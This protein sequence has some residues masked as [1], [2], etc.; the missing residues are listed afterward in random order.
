V[1]QIAHDEGRL[2]LAGEGR[3]PGLGC[4][5]TQCSGLGLCSSLFQLLRDRRPVMS[6]QGRR[7]VLRRS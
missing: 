2:L 4:T 7:D 5:C 6:W 1:R 3:S